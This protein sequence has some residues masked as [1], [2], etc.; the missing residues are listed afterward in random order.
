MYK[1]GVDLGGTNIAVGVIDENYNIKVTFFV[2]IKWFTQ[3]NQLIQELIN[4]GHNI[5]VFIDN[6]SDADYE[7]IDMVIKNINKQ[8]NGWCYNTNNNKE[9]IDFCKLKNNYTIA[10]IKINSKFPLSDIKENLIS[11]S[12][13]SLEINSQVRNELSTI[14]I[15]IKSKGLSLDNIENH[16]LE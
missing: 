5:G 16:L 8:K 10:P 3:N 4:N 11:G 2:E 7:W 13:L 14:I 15:Y 9:N 1:I 6:Y 12:L